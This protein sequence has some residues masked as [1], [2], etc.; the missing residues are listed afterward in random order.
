M[1]G[2]IFT[3]TNKTEKECFDRM[4]F[5]TNK[6]Y[7]DN[8]LQ[9]EKG[10]VL[11]LYNMDSDNYMELLKR[12]KKEERYCSSGLERGISLPGRG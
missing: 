5:A 7:G 11:F 6:L 12:R 1:K 10:D 9:I 3:C 4:I 8:V 2:Y